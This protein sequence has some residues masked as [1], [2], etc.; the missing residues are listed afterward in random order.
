MAPGNNINIGP[1]L[2]QSI[3]TPSSSTDYWALNTKIQALPQGHPALLSW[4]E[5]VV[6]LSTS[7]A[8][9]S[10]QT[11][12]E[13]EKNFGVISAHIDAGKYG[14]AIFM[15]EQIQNLH[16]KFTQAQDL[17]SA[18]TH[19]R[20][21]LTQWDDIY[22]VDR[23][24]DGTITQN[25]L[26]FHRRRF[27]DTNFVW[28]V[29]LAEFNREVS[30][31][32]EDVAQNN[33][34]I[35]AQEYQAYLQALFWEQGI[36]IV[37]REESEVNAIIRESLTQ[38]EDLLNNEYNTIFQQTT[39]PYEIT[40]WSQLDIWDFDFTGDFPEG[41]LTFETQGE[42]LE[43]LLFMK[44]TLNNMEPGSWIRMWAHM[45][46]WY[47]WWAS[48]L[49]SEAGRE[50]VQSAGIGIAAL[51]AVYFLK[52][53]G[54][55]IWSSLRWDSGNSSDSWSSRARRWTRW[56]TS[57]ESTSSQ[58]PSERW[59][60]AEMRE[61]FRNDS[62]ILNDI[63]TRNG[64]EHPMSLTSDEFDRI[65]ASQ[66]A[67]DIALNNTI[68]EWLQARSFPWG[69]ALHNILRLERPS[70][71]WSL[72]DNH[73]RITNIFAYI[74]S[75]DWN[76]LPDN[77]HRPTKADFMREI[78]T[79]VF[80]EN[81]KPRTIS[82]W[83]SL[84]NDITGRM[85]NLGITNSEG[86]ASLKNNINGNPTQ[87]TPAND[88]PAVASVDEWRTTDWSS[89]WPS[90]RVST[91]SE[92]EAMK[93]YGYSIVDRVRLEAFLI[94]PESINTLS[95]IQVRSMI[96]DIVRDMPV[97]E[98]TQEAVRGKLFQRLGEFQPGMEIHSLKS[99]NELGEIFNSI[100]LSLPEEERNTLINS[101]EWRA[102]GE[103]WNLDDFR[104]DKHKI[105]LR[106][107][108]RAASRA[109]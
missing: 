87:F 92:K 105:Y 2:D 7:I 25:E 31:L 70:L 76:S 63:F 101:R 90:E 48:G 78:S 16:D 103:V 51:F 27:E 23:N 22:R 93:T 43:F 94:D 61:T 55:A 50:G 8:S 65:S 97:D 28:W 109:I 49:T 81:G 80:T 83:K 107:L 95:K 9:L 89:G 100:L 35:T 34:N 4:Q 73:R 66:N 54:V 47:R 79:R 52:M 59:W 104:F 98:L 106:R 99:I 57:G 13:L 24:R 30:A 11:R 58:W 26:D 21:A 20:E 42:A 44:E 41:N 68:R 39:G 77:A 29:S 74:D 56:D 82:I 40:F 14:D 45:T 75:I 5:H 67:S 37:N 36:D 6:P 72:I 38:T 91:S 85:I 60:S 10:Q 46:E 18:S 33:P 96:D 17:I 19:T 69:Q 1:Q 64:I 15:I 12:N 86:I 88:T 53:A 71:T 3:S 102:F 108:F 84:Y 32:A 62:R